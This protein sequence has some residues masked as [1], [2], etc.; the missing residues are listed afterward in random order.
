MPRWDTWSFC[1]VPQHGGCQFTRWGYLRACTVLFPMHLSCILYQP[2]FENY[3]FCHFLYPM[4]LPYHLHLPHCP[5]LR[6]LPQSL[7][8][9]P[10]PQILEHIPIYLVAC[11]NHQHERMVGKAVVC[12]NHKCTG[13]L[14]RN[15]IAHNRMEVAMGDRREVL[16]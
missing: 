5:H 10:L 13:Y 1:C 8:W 12:R 15:F 14:G 16:N 6:H 9:R 3:H 11:K 2:L 7:L 4:T